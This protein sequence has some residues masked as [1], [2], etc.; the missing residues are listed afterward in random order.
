MMPTG[1]VCRE[2]D[3]ECDFPEWY[4]GCMFYQCLYPQWEPL[5]YGGY[6]YEKRCNDHDQQCGQTFGKE[7]SIAGGDI[8]QENLQRDCFGNC[9][10]IRNTYLKLNLE[11]P[12]GEFSERA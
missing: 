5:H 4:S 6:C 9:A 10:I 12:V 2:K 1:T 7:A 3:N 8:L 11:S